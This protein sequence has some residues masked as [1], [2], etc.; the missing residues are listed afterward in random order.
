MFAQFTDA[1][2]IFVKAV[3][4]GAK[5]AGQSA[6]ILL[7]MFTFTF[8]YCVRE[9]AQMKPIKVFCTCYVVSCSTCLPRFSIVYI[10]THVSKCYGFSLF[11]NN[12]NTVIDKLKYI[13]YSN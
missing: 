4:M 3:L 10:V 7:N 1:P 5:G 6:F 2:N 11:N 12:F 9:G 8:S 13:Y